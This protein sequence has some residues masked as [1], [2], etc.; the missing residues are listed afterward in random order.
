MLADVDKLEKI[1]GN[2]LSN[3]LKYTPSKGDI[4]FRFNIITGEYAATLFPEIKN[5]TNLSYALIQIE[6]SGPGIPEDKLEDIFLRY[7]QIDRNQQAKYN[8]GTGIGLY[9]TRQLLRLHHGKIKAENSKNGGAVFSFI[10][11]VDNTAYSENEIKILKKQDTIQLIRNKKSIPD[12]T[13]TPAKEQDNLKKETI[14][15]VDDDI[16]ISFYLNRLLSHDYHIINKYDGES[17]FNSLAQLNPTLIISD[18]LMPGLNGYEL[19]KRIKDDVSFCHIPVILLTAK[20]L[21]EEQVEGLETG[22]NAYVTKPFEPEYLTALIKSQLKNKKLLSSILTSNT[23]P[24]NIKENILSPKDKAF[25][26]RLYELMEQEIG[27]SEMNITRIAE[28]MRM[29]RTKFY[30][31][32]KGLTG[33]NPNTLIKTYKLNRAA[34]Y[35]KEGK[36][37]VSE[38]AEMTGF[39]NLSHF[40]VSF[41]KQFNCNPSEYKG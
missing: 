36:Y 6:D 4:K 21:M 2:I 23:R 28:R 18:I 26:D 27:N 34:E 30:N 9:F 25:I 7:Y 31:K 40:S 39:V 29:S 38:I 3:A 24:A 22:A 14:M 32:I 17:A 20:T 19:C 10:I 33:E 13:I 11:P 37:N 15:I 5:K 12:E 35:L 1:L 16:E 41:K 8:W